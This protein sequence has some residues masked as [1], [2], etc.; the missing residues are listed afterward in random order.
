MPCPSEASLVSPSL[1]PSPLGRRDAR[2]LSD[3]VKH[4]PSLVQ[5]E[6]INLKLWME[7]DQARK[8]CISTN[9]VHSLC[10]PLAGCCFSGQNV[11]GLCRKSSVFSSNALK[12]ICFASSF[13]PYT[14]CV[15]ARGGS[16]HNSQHN[17]CCITIQDSA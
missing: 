1:P 15:H 6:I 11:R 2:L 4:I 9:T 16:I 3:Q 12:G 10:P 8:L 14:A 13:T 5:V 7:K 17:S